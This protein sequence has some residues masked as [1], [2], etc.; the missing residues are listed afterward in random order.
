MLKDPFWQFARRFGA[1]KDDSKHPDKQREKNSRYNPI[2]PAADQAA[3]ILFHL[4]KSPVPK[5]TLTEICT[6]LGLH[7]S[8][9]Y[10][11]LNSLKKYGFVEKDPNS[12]QY[13]LGLGLVPLAR[14][15]LDNLDI[16]DLV[17]PFLRALAEKTQCTV[18]FGLINAEQVYVIAK[19]EGNPNIGVTI[20]LGHRFHVTS[21]AHGKAII[22]FLP[23]AEKENILSRNKLYFYGES[24]SIN[25]DK[26]RKELAQC[27]NLGFAADLGQLQSGINAVSAP[28]FGFGGKI[29]GCVI[30]FGTFSEDFVPRYGNQVA[31]VASEI[32]LKLS[33]DATKFHAT[34]D[35]KDPS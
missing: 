16:R 3:R 11:L 23:N 4:G 32:S 1:M 13:S 34:K 33:P 29:L 30:L 2:A 15:V 19:H 28:V 14:K 12:K 31:N 6:E 21:G 27:R 22:A 25:L 5:M 20:R 18:L 24:G 26:L 10:S 8:K 9:G 35:L 7:K 17:T